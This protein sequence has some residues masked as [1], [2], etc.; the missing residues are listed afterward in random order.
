MAELGSRPRALARGASAR[1]RAL[2]AAPA[3]GVAG[4][5]RMFNRAE[6]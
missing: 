1:S 3:G 2:Q 5:S 4:L 6:G